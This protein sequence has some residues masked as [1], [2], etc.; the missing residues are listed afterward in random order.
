[1]EHFNDLAAFVAVAETKA[2]AAAARRLNASTSGVSK[3]VNRLEQRLGVRLFTRTTRRVAL[4]TEGEQ[5]YLRSRDILEALADAESELTDASSALRGRIRVDMP[6]HYGER[7]VIPALL[8]FRAQHPAVD[9][10]IRLSDTVTNL[11][12][13]SVD[14]AVRFGDLGDSRIK[15]KRLGIG[16][17]LTCAAPAYLARHGR[18]KT[19]ADLEAHEC[20][21]FRFRSSQRLLNWRFLVHGSAIE[22]EPKT[23]ITV[24]DSGA[25]RRLG[26]LGAGVIQDLDSNVADEITAGQL[27]EV[28]AKHSIPAFPVTLIWPA[29]RHQTRR[30]RAMIDFLTAEL[31]A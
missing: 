24:N 22:I 31:G 13:E 6:I 26:L 18:P 14:L 9:L 8:A 21:A 11:V 4:T 5:F 16:R 27:V 7:H 15:S 2:F 1:M 19:I 23:S 10:D 29:G 20:V 12:E 17:L 28:L 3:S 25:Y 30:V